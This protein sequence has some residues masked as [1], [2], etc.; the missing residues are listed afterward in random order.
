VAPQG[1]CRECLGEA[2]EALQGSS[3]CGGGMWWLTS[4]WYLTSDF[5]LLS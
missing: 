1:Q 5:K 3:C 4:Y 2:Q